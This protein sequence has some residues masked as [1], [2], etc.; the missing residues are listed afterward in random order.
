M[1][2]NP[3]HGVSLFHLPKLYN[4]SREIQGPE[5]RNFRIRNFGVGAK[6]LLRLCGTFQPWRAR[7]LPGRFET[8]GCLGKMVCPRVKRDT[9]WERLEHAPGRC[10]ACGEVLASPMHVH[11]FGFRYGPA[12]GVQRRLYAHEGATPYPA[13]APIDRKVPPIADA[14]L[15]WL[16]HL[17]GVA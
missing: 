1:S 15:A 7:I 6:T 2:A 16:A 5:P 10:A 8:D 14:M 9:R 17:H 11:Q 3:A 12:Y 4:C 13:S